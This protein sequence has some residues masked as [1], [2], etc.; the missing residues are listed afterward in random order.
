MCECV[1]KTVV[2]CV[3]CIGWVRSM[4]VCVCGGGG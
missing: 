1:I 2:V 3:A 4:C